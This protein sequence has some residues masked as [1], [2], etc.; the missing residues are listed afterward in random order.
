MCLAHQSVLPRI[1]NLV[2]QMRILCNALTG[3]YN[4]TLEGYMSILKTHY[5][6]HYLYIHVY[7][8]RLT[9]R[10]ATSHLSN[11]LQIY[12]YVHH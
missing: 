11:G 9:H 1:V 10:R 2:V 8:C 12:M 7:R 4:P 5:N 3:W 6:A